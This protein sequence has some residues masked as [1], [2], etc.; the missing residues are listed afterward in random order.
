LGQ[1][2][3]DDDDDIDEGKT[4]F[5]LDIIGIALHCTCEDNN[6]GPQSANFFLYSEGFYRERRMDGWRNG[7]EC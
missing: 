3:D 1:R 4:G 7:M 2:D 6:N 5:L